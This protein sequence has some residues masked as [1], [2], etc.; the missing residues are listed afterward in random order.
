LLMRGKQMCLTLNITATAPLLSAQG[1][2]NEQAD[3][4]R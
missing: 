4:P 2:R 3:I 1:E